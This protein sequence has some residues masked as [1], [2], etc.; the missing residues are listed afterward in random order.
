MADNTPLSPGLRYPN[1][2][3]LKTL[4][5]LTAVT[6]FDVKSI[7]I[8][9]SY[10]EDIFNNTA[11]GYLMVVDASGFI[12]SLQMNGNEFIRIT[13]GKIAGETNNVID[14]LFRIF[15]IAKRNP[16]NDGNTETYSIYFCSEELL[17]SEQYKVSKSYKNSDITTN[18]LNI[19]D[20]Y[21]K[22]PKNKIGVIEN[23]YGVYDFIVPNLKPFDAINWMS[24]YARPSGGNLGADMLFYENKFGFNF[25]SMQNLFD[26]AVYSTYSYNPK[27]YNL[28]NS[29]QTSDLRLTNVISYEIMDS[30]DTL[31]SI[32]QG[33]FANRLLS[34]DPLLRRFKITDFDY[35][36]YSN[37]AKTL[38]GAPV[39]NNY[40]NRYGD[41]L[42]QT[43][44]STY[45]LVL[46]NFKQKDS[47]YIKENDSVPHDIM[48]E[49]YIPYRT[50]QIPLLTYT[51]VKIS[52]PGDTEL[53]VGRLVNFN[54]LSKNPNNR[55]LDKYYSGK[56]LITAVRHLLNLN[57]YRTIL[58]LAKESTVGGY[59]SVNNTGTIWQTTSGGK[60]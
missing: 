56:Y 35:G 7:M 29:S 12:E 40:K 8:E 15:K 42:N 52:V 16:E 2:F 22:I 23:T 6:T 51:R 31:G 5:I 49:T 10:N 4:T 26:N 14:K 27:N 13:L 24:N 48:A 37:I 46:S 30:F 54:L 43:P 59:S 32:N 60:F 19:I 21:L 38:N 36:K 50:S 25:R 44:E 53:T 57:E 11:S 18:V 20:K 9:L 28:T 39:T 47:K 41:T 33:V 55:E 17:I 3:S 45:K 1:D 58:E 34:V